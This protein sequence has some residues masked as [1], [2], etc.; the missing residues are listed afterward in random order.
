MKKLSFRSQFAINF[1]IVLLLSIVCTLVVWGASIYFLIT[2]EGKLQPANYYEQQIPDILQFIREHEDELL[3][4]DFQAELEQVVPLEGMDYQVVNLSGETVYGS[5]EEVW[6]AGPHEVVSKIN[7][8]WQRNGQYIVYHPVTNEQGGLTGMVIFRYSLNLSSSNPADAG[9]IL[10]FI[11]INMAAPFL[12]I[13]MFTLL[14][15]R[16]VGKRLEPPIS[17]LIQGAER[18]QRH[19][20][21]FTFPSEGGSKE[22]IQLAGAFEEMR[23]ALHNSLQAQW[24][25]EQERR[26]MV[27]AIAHDLR[28]PLTIIQGHVDNLLENP[29]KRAERLEDYLQTI[30]KSTDRAARLLNEMN[31]VSEIERPDFALNVQNTDIVSF[32]KRKIEE[33]NLL[34]EAAQLEFRPEL[35]LNHSSGW[36]MIDSHRLEQMVDNVISNSLRFT[37]P[38]GIIQWRIAIDENEV[39]ME[40]KDTGPGFAEEELPHIFQKFYQG[41]S[42]RSRSKGHAGLGL[43]IVKTLAEKHGGTAA[44]KNSL[45]GGASVSFT[46]KATSL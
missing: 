43:Y 36:M 41:D 3:L 30:R 26:D 17:R 10:L 16:K 6:I 13:L 4:K 29:T 40:V 39:S 19:D 44:A 24:R 33:Y 7:T 5:M 22:I 18:I 2:D 23:S 21:D 14:L 42:S 15:A 34:C 1:I 27:A 8:T 9:F 11:T 12:F 28:T 20:L 46:I 25:L 45:E 35:H 31:A 38:G 32:C 37:P